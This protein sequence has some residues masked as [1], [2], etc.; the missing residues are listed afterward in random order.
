[1]AGTAFTAMAAVLAKCATSAVMIR[2][3]ADR[4]TTPTARLRQ[5]L[6]ARGPLTAGELAMAVGLD[7]SGLVGALLKYDRKH[8]RVTLEDGR[9]KIKES[10]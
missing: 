4:A 10:A 5:L 7:N 9:Y 2:Q 1:M 8:G 6:Q 3:P